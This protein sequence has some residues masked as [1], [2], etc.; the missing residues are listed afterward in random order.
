M[1]CQ[2][3]KVCKNHRGLKIHQTKSGCQSRE[4]HR[5][6]TGL[7]GETGEISSRASNHSTRSLSARVFS[8]FG[9][10]ST[11]DASRSID[12][13]LSLQDSTQATIRE[14]QDD[15]VPDTEGDSPIVRLTTTEEDSPISGSSLTQNRETGQTTDPNP[16]GVFTFPEEWRTSSRT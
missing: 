14:E 7:P 13:L 6:R 15:D 4:K 2:C 8:L 10:G 5:Q 9:S 1:V 12:E 16:E 3:G 11:A